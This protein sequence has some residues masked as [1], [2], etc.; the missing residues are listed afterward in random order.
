MRTATLP[1]GHR[2]AMLRKMKQL[3]ALF[4][5]LTLALAPFA[6]V[7]AAAAVF[8]GRIFA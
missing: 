6:L 3:F 2:L 4:A 5:L 7:P 1:I 8:T